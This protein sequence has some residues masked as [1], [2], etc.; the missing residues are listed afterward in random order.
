MSFLPASWP[1]SAEATSGARLFVNAVR[2]LR[3]PIDDSE[4]NTRIQQRFAHRDDSFLDL[5]R[6]MVYA[7][8]T[9]PYRRL[10][11]LAGC[12]YG[13]LE[14]LVQR[15]G[16]EEALCEL[17]RRG[18]YLTVDE[19]KGRRPVVRGSSSFD[20]DPRQLRNPRLVPDFVAQTSGSRGARA[21]VPMELQRLRE[22]L[23]PRL[24]EDRYRVYAQWAAPGTG[25]M[26]WPLRKVLRGQVAER[27]FSL[28][29]PVG[30]GLHA[31]YA[32]S[33]RAVRWAGLL[34]GH[35]FPRP[36]YVP[37]SDPRPIVRWMAAVLQ[38]GGQPTLSSSVSAA[39]RVCQAAGDSGIALRGARFDISGE[40]ATP[41]R[42]A[43]IQRAGATVR[44]AYAATEPGTIGQGCLEP[45]VADEVHFLQDRLAVV[46]PGQ[47]GG[48]GLPPK[49]LL[50]TSLLPRA[51]LILINVSTGD[52]SEVFKR[53]C[54]CPLQHV[55]WTTHMH[56]IRSFEKLTAG[57]MTFFDSDVIR[58][59]DEVLP[60][61]FGG[62]PADYQ[63]VD[64]ESDDGAPHVRLLVH[65]RLG[66]VDTEAVRQTFLDA[67]G[68]GTGVE[69]VMQLVWQEAGLPIVEHA[70]PFATLSGKIQHV[71]LLPR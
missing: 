27:W 28:V 14:R 30:S 1:S 45:D 9:S 32:W 55:G 71:H 34:A 26:Q 29:D 17:Y 53:D 23:V 50:M 67:I 37:L 62:G 10:L 70:S 38:A 3:S 42:I 4:F 20:L 57:G 16:L 61:R 11:R 12:E 43:A 66:L 49:A 19:S 56:T 41:A 15:D 69:R 25:A 59:L 13:D 52:Q 51:R 46:Q 48:P 8:S 5:V 64:D 22:D 40:P 68:G 31:K 65:P 21:A 39:V 36:V 33:A 2:L 60:R 47:D 44:V 24:E 6:E 63:L 54:G 18:V 35:R 7:S 58:V